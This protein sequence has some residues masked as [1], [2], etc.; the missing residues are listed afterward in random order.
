MILAI[1]KFAL[2]FAD[3]LMRY[4][5]EGQL[6]EAGKQIQNAENFKRAAAEVQRAEDAA[7]RIRAIIAA[8]PG[9][10]PDDGFGS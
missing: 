7:A 5:S 10:V 8:H 9:G 4:I 6:L 1:I 2:G 3:S